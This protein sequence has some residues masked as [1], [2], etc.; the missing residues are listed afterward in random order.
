MKSKGRWRIRAC[1]I[2]ICCYPHESKGRKGV[3]GKPNASE[4]ASL[5]SHRCTILGLDCKLLCEGYNCDQLLFVCF[6]KAWSSSHCSFNLI[7]FISFPLFFLL[8]FPFPHTCHTHKP[9]QMINSLSWLME[10]FIS[11]TPLFSS[12]YSLPHVNNCRICTFCR[13][14]SKCEEQEIF[15]LGVKT[16]SCVYLCVCVCVS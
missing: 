2:S 4:W 3:K 10:S 1:L 7:L 15:T 12:F 13:N 14:R 5:H 9:N 8:F 6:W 11:F 16:N